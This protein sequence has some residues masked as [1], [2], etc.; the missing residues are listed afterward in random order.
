MA[1]PAAAGQVLIGRDARKPTP[2]TLFRFYGTRDVI[3]GLGALGAASAGGDARGWVAAGIAADVLD[4]G[5]ML[6]EW[7]DIPADKR[8]P[9]LLAALGAA[10]AGAALLARGA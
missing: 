9:G 1:A 8:V 5:V 6:T 10:G 3:L 4:A 2:R 7:T